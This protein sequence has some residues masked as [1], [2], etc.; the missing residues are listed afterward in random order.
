MRKTT[1][2][3]Q[4]Y[5]KIIERQGEQ[6]RPKEKENLQKEDQQQVP[7]TKSTT[8]TQKKGNKLWK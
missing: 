8:H 6:R 7:L 4:T 3:K 2:Q 1:S 5:S